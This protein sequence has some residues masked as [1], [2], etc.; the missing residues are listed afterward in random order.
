[1]GVADLDNTVLAVCAYDRYGNEY[2]AALYNRQQ[3][4][5]EQQQ[6]VADFSMVATSDGVELHFAG[7]QPVQIYSAS[8]QLIRQTTATDTY[9]QPLP[10]KGM[11]IIR[12][13]Q[14]V[15]KIVR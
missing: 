15:K 3:T 14:S 13:G 5:I 8:G 4:G 7:R 9:S 6:E 1:M 10:D 12:V 11:Y 2:E